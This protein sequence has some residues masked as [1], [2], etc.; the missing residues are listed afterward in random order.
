MRQSRKSSLKEELVGA[1]E[2]EVSVKHRAEWAK[3]DY[4]LTA[5]ESCPTNTHSRDIWS[6]KIISLWEPIKCS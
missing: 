4:A 3:P 5:Q 2:K 6:C 1:C